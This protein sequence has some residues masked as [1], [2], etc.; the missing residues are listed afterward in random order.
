[1]L[2]ATGLQTSQPWPAMARQQAVKAA[3]I[4]QPDQGVELLARIG[5]VLTHMVVDHHAAARHLGLHD[6][7]DQRHTAAAGAAGL[8]AGLQRSDGGGAIGHHSTE[9]AFAEVV[10]PA[11][12]CAVGQRVHS[13]RGFGLAATSTPISLSLVRMSAP[14]N[15]AASWPASWLATTLAIW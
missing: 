4:A 7:C 3:D 14:T 15:T 8:G 11:A 2:A 13:Q 12:L 1:M 5:Q 9:L 10:A 6:L